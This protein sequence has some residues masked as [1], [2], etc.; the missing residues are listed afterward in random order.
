MPDDQ[1]IKDMGK[2]IISIKEKP[3]RLYFEVKKEAIKEVADYLFNKMACRLSTGTAQ[4]TYR[5]IEVMYHFSHDASGR[6]YCP[7]VVLDKKDCRSDSITPLFIGAEWIEREMSE[8]FGITFS[9]LPDP[10]PLL[11]GNHPDGLK[12]PWI[13]RREQ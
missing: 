7:I 6:Y 1:I 2:N 3:G 5:G 11:T 13:H 12:T 8:M 4:E 10:S 9:G